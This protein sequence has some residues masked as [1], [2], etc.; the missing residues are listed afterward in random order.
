MNL[1]LTGP[2][3]SGKTTVGQLCAQKLNRQFVDVDEHIVA[4]TGRS[5]PELFSEQGETTFRALETEAIAELA[6]QDNLVIAPGGGA[7]EYPANRAAAA[8]P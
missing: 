7:L 2:P 4:K 3:G 6:A 1:V 8:P 5:I